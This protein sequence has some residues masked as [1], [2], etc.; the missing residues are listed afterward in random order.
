[1]TAPP[2]RYADLEAAT[3]MMA[4]AIA[5]PDA[6]LAGIYAARPRPGRPP[7][8]AELHLPRLPPRLRRP[9]TPKSIT[10]RPHH[11]KPEAEA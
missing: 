10:A 6:T 2:N 5:D 1:M 11:D 9:L 8:P 4:A 3:V 7:A